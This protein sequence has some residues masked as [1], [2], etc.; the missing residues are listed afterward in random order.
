M[1][2]DHA[3][4]HIFQL[5]RPADYQCFVDAK[6]D[7]FKKAPVPDVLIIGDSLVSDALNPR[8]FESEYHVRAH[9][10]G[11]YHATPFELFFLMEK[12]L[13][14]HPVRPEHLII[15]V[16]PVFFSSPPSIGRYTPVIMNDFISVARMGF[17]SE[18]GMSAPVFLKSLRE[19]YLM[20]HLLNQICHK[21]YQPTREIQSVFNGHLEFY[22]TLPDKQWETGS[23]DDPNEF[24]IN[25]VQLKYFESLIELMKQNQINVVLVNIPVWPEIMKRMRDR[26]EFLHFRAMLKDLMDKYVIKIV[27]LDYSL[28]SPDISREWFLN[29]EHFNHKGSVWFTHEVCSRLNVEG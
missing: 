17:Y 21:P 11:I 15:G 7:V 24:K 12:Y 28:E 9:N 8:V 20:K 27:N 3:L 19:R 14:T 2:L 26:P 25:A 29:Q 22:N 5:A 18:E 23:F 1:A 10:L 16:H 13:K 6:R 4:Y